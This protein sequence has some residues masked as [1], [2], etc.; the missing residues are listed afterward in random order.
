MFIGQAPSSTSNPDEPLSGRCGE[1]IAT[2]LGISMAEFLKYPRKNLLPSYPGKRERTEKGD[3]FASIPGSVAADNLAGLIDPEVPFV[4]LGREVARAFGFKRFEPLRVT[5]LNDRP[6][7]MLPHTSSVNRWWNNPK[8]GLK[9]A[10]ALRWFVAPHLNIPPE[11]APFEADA[12]PAAESNWI[13]ARW[14]FESAAVAKR[15]DAHVREQ[16]SWY[17]EMTADVVHAAAHFI[18]RGGLIYDVGASTGNTGRALAPYIRD[19]EARIVSIEASAEMSK[20]WNGPGELFTTDALCFEFQKFDLCLVLLTI[21]F[22]PVTYR[23]DLVKRLT[24]LIKPGGALIIVDKVISPPGYVGTVFRRMAMKWKLDAG[25]KPDEILAK[26]LSLGGV[27]RPIDPNIIPIGA[28]RFF[29][30]GEFV[31]WIIARNE[32]GQIR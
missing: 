32:D 20:L 24:S 11:P 19:R 6:V 13:P 5:T 30:R 27:Q 1:R 8:N 16:L 26:E 15:F 4:L 29:Q 14:T 21:M 9:A 18:P 22:M 3:F 28:H 7:L 31:G 12:P 23:E 10:E 2:L 25:A 17:D